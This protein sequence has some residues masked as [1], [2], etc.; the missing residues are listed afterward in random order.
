[1]KDMLTYKTRIGALGFL[2]SSATA[3][4]GVL[5]LG[6][7][8]QVLLLEWVQANIAEFGGNPK[9]VTLFGL[10]A[11]AHSIGHHVMNYKE[12][13]P[14]F[15]R[16]I[17]ESGAATSRAVHPYDAKLHETQFSE[18]IAEVGCSSVPNAEIFSCLRAAP[19]KTVTDA[20]DT[21]FDKYNPSVRWAFQPVIDGDIIAQRPL[22][23]WH[24]K[25]WNKVPIMTGFNHNE[26]TMYV[27]SG[28]STPEEFSSFFSTLLPQFSKSDIKT[29]EKLYPDPSVDGTSPYKDTRDIA[30]GAQYKR[31]EA[32]YGHYAY[33]CPVRQTASLAAPF[34][35]QPVFLYHWALN[36]T[37]KGGANH[38]DQIQYETMLE[39][40]INFSPKQKEVA[41]TFHAYVTSFITTGNPNKLA[42]RQAQRPA[43]EAF[44][45]ADPKVTIFGEGND[46]RAGGEGMGLTVQVVP[47]TWAKEECDFWWSKTK[48][49][50]L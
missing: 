4:E 45:I 15:H 35:E 30:V 14:L 40:V 44:D 46:E 11:G 21:I 24:S 8:D 16:V 26:G 22:K 38:A 31:T 34:Q 49:S 5:N 37:V 23:A 47:D 48:L 50:E 1:M 18:Y 17:I 19:S 20:S 13:D 42:G 29:I 28:T 39:E 2:P 25:K 43:W 33:V 7:K 12:E 41:E 3:E 10:S 9:E 6:L 27:P 36:R 32:A